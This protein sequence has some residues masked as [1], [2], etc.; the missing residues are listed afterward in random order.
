MRVRPAVSRAPLGELRE[1]VSSA[2]CLASLL[3]P[4]LNNISLK[5]ASNKD[6]AGERFVCVLKTS[7]LGRKL[8]RED[9]R[10]RASSH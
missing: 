9:T 10:D 3:C 5:Q 8:L 6:S 7:F 4:F 1:I 2:S